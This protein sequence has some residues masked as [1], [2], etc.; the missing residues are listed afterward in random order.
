LRLADG[1]TPIAGAKE[2][3]YL[4]RNFQ[5][6]LQAKE[7]MRQAE[8]TGRRAANCKRMEQKGS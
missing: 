3:A 7:N 8:G 5:I 4:R 2:P 1:V 6:M